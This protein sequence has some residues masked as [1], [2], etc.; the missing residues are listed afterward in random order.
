MVG[1]TFAQTSGNSQQGSQ[2]DGYY[3]CCD[4]SYHTG[5][6]NGRRHMRGRHMYGNQS[7]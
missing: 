3:S 1:F 2:D 4:G 5:A 6:N 7:N